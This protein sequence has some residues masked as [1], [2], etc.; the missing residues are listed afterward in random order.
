MSYLE[1]SES[2]LLAGCHGCV[3]V[4]CTGGQKE[5]DVLASIIELA[6]KKQQQAVKITKITLERQCDPEFLTEMIE[7]AKDNDVILSMAC[8]AGVQLVAEKAG[9]MK[10]FPAIDT[11]F[12]GAIQEKGLLGRALPDLRRLQA[13]LTGGICPVTRCAKSLMN[14]PCGGSRNGICEIDAEIRRAAGN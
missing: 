11:N 4:C 6:R 12:I 1:G 5:V 9:P 3:T 14:G 2:I 7:K 8:G 13:A 10:V